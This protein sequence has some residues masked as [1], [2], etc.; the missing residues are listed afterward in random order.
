VRKRIAETLELDSQKLVHFKRIPLQELNVT[1]QFLIFMAAV[2]LGLTLLGLIIKRNNCWQYSIRMAAYYT[3]A[4]YTTIALIAFLSMG[5]HVAGIID[6]NQIVFVNIDTIA[7]K[8]IIVMGT[9]MSP[10]VVFWG[11]AMFV[12]PVIWA[13]HGALEL[14][15][16]KAIAY[17]YGGIGFGYFLALPIIDRLLPFINELLR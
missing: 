15:T 14:S 10:V 4:L 17:S 6:L 13:K 11:Y 8:Q 16:W 9:V 2:A 3:A 12:M 5:F 7:P 1:I